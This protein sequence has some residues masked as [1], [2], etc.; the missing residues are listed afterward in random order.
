MKYKKEGKNL[1]SDIISHYNHQINNLIELCSTTYL[2]YWESKGLNFQEV[3][4][5]DLKKSV[6]DYN[7]PR[8]SVLFQVKLKDG[9]LPRIKQSDAIFLLENLIKPPKNIDPSLFLKAS[10][11]FEQSTDL[12][13]EEEER[14][15]LIV[16]ELLKIRQQG[17]W[18]EKYYN[19]F[20]KLS[21]Y[22]P[23]NKKTFTMLKKYVKHH[24]SLFREIVLVFCQALKVG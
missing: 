8:L 2:T 21:G 5:Q 15:I 3:Y 13:E 9:T 23:V 14:L 24:N 16:D 4:I 12:I 19:A 10:F 6:L 7:I 22:L 11:A 20:N 18:Y 17:V 1:T